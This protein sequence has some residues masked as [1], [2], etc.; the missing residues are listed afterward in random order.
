MTPR[1]L[2]LFLAAAGAA[3]GA[4][5]EFDRIVN[6]IENHYHV[7]RTHIPLMGVAN[8]FVKVARP[9]GTSGFKLAVFEDLD[10]PSG[11]GDQEEL[12]HFM[13][14]VCRGGMHALVVTHSRR[15]GESAYILAGE[16][17][18]ASKL[19]IATFERHEATVIEVQVDWDTLLRMIGSPDEAHR[20][21]RQER[22]ER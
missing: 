13:E 2:A 11:Y 8:F 15:D 5:R 16:I 6:A 1:V 17:G 10:A 4:D 19:L 7:S 3:Y 21:F 14:G 12:D 22:D 18:R 9:A 20:L